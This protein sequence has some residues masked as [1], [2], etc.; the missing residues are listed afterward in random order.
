MLSTAK[1][2]E[3]DSALSVPCHKSDKRNYFLIRES[4]SHALRERFLHLKNVFLL[5]DSRKNFFDFNVIS[6]IET[7]SFKSKKFF[8][9]ISKHY[10]QMTNNLF[11]IIW[12]SNISLN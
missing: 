5:Y 4:V 10:V 7:L 12:Q 6:L 1:W 2:Y 8:Y 9:L 11:L 3:N